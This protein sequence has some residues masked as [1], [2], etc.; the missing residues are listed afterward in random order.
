MSVS[1]T[2]GWSRPARLFHW[3]TAV[4][5]AIQIPLGFWMVEVYEVYS[6]TW[7]D[8]TWV[9]RTSNWHHT[10]GF[11]VLGLTALRFSW[12]LMQPLPE[13][14]TRLSRFQHWLARFTHLFLYALLFIYPLSGWASLSA[15]EGQFPIFL[16]GWE[17]V[18]RLVPQVA[19]DAFFNYEFFAE[20]HRWCWKVG[21]GVL[22]LH[23][24]GALWHHCVAKDSV[25]KRMWHGA[26]D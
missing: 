4:L 22:G 21:A 18:P 17:S 13:P 19:E 7:G 2:S 24:C 6:A 25:L 1:Q 20:I 11:I 10:I 9:M 15:Y 26:A 8:D 16:F 12:R 5:I 14:V 3:G 23:I